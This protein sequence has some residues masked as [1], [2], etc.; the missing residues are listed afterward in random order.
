M[1]TFDIIYHTQHN[2]IEPVHVLSSLEWS[3]GHLKCRG[4]FLS[5]LRTIYPCFDHRKFTYNI[6]SHGPCWKTCLCNW[7][8]WVNTYTVAVHRFAR[9]R[10]VHTVLQAAWG[11]SRTPLG[12]VKRALGTRPFRLVRQTGTAH[13]HGGNAS[14]SGAEETA[15]WSFG[16]SASSESAWIQPYRID[17]HFGRQAWAEG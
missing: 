8:F 7:D 2:P 12:L 9:A 11:K 4:I 15:F 16:V 13:R 3:V 10:L 17:W 5:L 1:H 14:G 6:R